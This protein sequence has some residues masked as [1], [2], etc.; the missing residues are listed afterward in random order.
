MRL[1]ILKDYDQVSRWAARLVADRIRAFAPT[2]ARRYT[3]GLPTGSSPVGMYDELARMHKEEGLSFRN[4]VT[5]NMD[6]YAGLPPDNPCSYSYFMRTHL[7]DRIDIPPENTHLPNGN[8]PDLPA[9]G[10]EYEKAIAEAG[11]I[12]LFVGG[13]GTD[14]HIA[15]NE[16]GSSLASRTRP[17]TLTPGTR[18]DNA[19]FFDNDLSKVPTLA[20]TVGVGTVMAADEVMLLVSGYNKARALKSLVEEGVNHLCPASCLQLHPKAVVVCDEAATDELMVKTVR[21]FKE[22]AGAGI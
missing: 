4:V 19:R 13:I 8:A 6:E 10:A 15:F 22:I 1:V 16:P 12:R 2:P 11:G 17:K 7:F 5:F 3:L 9:A 20:L 18:A 21:Y 14:G